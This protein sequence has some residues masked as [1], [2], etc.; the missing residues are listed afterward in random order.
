MCIIKEDFPMKVFQTIS[1]CLDTCINAQRDKR[2]M[3]L[4][5]HFH[6]VGVFGI[7]ILQPEKGDLENDF[8]QAL[9]NLIVS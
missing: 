8:M 5:M 9:E 4:K 7:S 1:L 6:V 2:E 3:R